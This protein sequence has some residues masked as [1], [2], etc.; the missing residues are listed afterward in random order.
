M[1]IIT[2]FPPSTPPS[3]LLCLFVF[4]LLCT[5]LL[6]E[7]IFSNSFNYFLLSIC[8]HLECK[9]SKGKDFDFWFTDA[10][11]VPRTVSGIP[12]V[13]KSFLSEYWM[14]NFFFCLHQSN[15]P[16]IMTAAT[17]H[18]IGKFQKLMIKYNSLLW[19]LPCLQNFMFLSL[20]HNIIPLVVGRLAG[21]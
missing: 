6:I 9:L 7:Y 15:H 8:S 16:L 18:L 14:A 11:M 17:G 20:H 19:K 1:L 5:Y 21:L 13:L 4:F 12:R 2:P 3:L 10:L